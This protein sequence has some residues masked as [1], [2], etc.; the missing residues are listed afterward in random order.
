MLFAA[1]E[2]DEPYGI[3]MLAERL[4]YPTPHLPKGIRD[5][6]DFLDRFMRFRPDEQVTSIS[7]KHF[8]SA[9][10]L[11]FDEVDY[12]QNGGYSSGVIT[13]IGKFLIVVKCNEKSASELAE[14]TQSVAAIQVRR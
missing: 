8:T 4:N 10:G 5:S 9:N 12:M 11:V 14:M 6:T 2:G 1:R 3:V 13:T 7:K